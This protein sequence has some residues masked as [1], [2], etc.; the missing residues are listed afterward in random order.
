MIVKVKNKSRFFRDCADELLELWSCKSNKIF[1]VEAEDS[2]RYVKKFY[3]EN[4]KYLVSP[5]PSGKDAKVCRK[6]NPNGSIWFEVRNDASALNTY[7]HLTEAQPFHTDGS[8]I[9]NF[10]SS[11]IM[12]RMKMK[13]SEGILPC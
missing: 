2:P 6:K 1:V 13:V 11:T 7:R 10:P 3:F 5:F 8:Y 4:F 9:S 12:Y